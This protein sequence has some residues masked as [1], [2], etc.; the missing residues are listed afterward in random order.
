L[1]ADAQAGKLSRHDDDTITRVLALSGRQVVPYLGW[2]RIDIAERQAGR[3]QQ[4]PRIKQTD[5]GALLA[6]ARGDQQDAFGATKP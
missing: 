5:T 1:V 6:L 4:R 2:Q 3:A